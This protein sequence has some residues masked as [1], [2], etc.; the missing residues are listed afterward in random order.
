MRLGVVELDADPAAAGRRVRAAG[1]RSRRGSRRA[2]SA[3]ASPRRAA[4][5]C[6]ASRAACRGAR[7][8]DRLHCGKRATQPARG[9]LALA[10]GA[11]EEAA[12]VLVRLEVE[13]EG[14]GQA[15]VP[16]PHPLQCSAAVAATGARH[17][18]RAGA[19]RTAGRA[20]RAGRAGRGRLE[21][22]PR[23][24][25]EHVL[26]PVPVL[27]GRASATRWST[28]ACRR[29][30]RAISR[31]S[32]STSPRAVLPAARPGLRRVPAGAAAG[33]RRARAHLHAS[34]PTSRPSRAPG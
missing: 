27:R 7:F 12:L 18:R 29:C 33:V 1:R 2:C 22:P 34:T 3:R 24:R 6:S 25:H 30:A 4:R 14:A 19:P 10:E 26:R 16:E 5:R 17:G 28:S 32:S 21:S 8:Q 11:G 9:E 13:Q 31:P 20:A 15:R 23:A